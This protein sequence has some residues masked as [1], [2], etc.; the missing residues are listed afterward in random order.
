[1]AEL[2][3]WPEGDAESPFRRRLVAWA[4]ASSK[5]LRRF[6]GDDRFVVRLVPSLQLQGA[7]GLL[8]TARRLHAELEAVGVAVPPR[9]YV[10]GSRHTDGAPQAFV[11]ARTVTGTPLSDLPAGAGAGVA[12]PAEELCVAL[13][14]HLETKFEAGGAYLPD[15]KLEQFVHGWVDDPT[16]VRPYLVDLDPGSVSIE[17]RTAD[18]LALARLQWRIAEVANM[19]V[20]LEGIA[21]VA[22]AAARARLDGVTASPVFAGAEPRVSA[23][24]SAL[25]DGATLDGLEWV[26]EEMARRGARP[27]AAEDRHLAQ[28]LVQVTRFNPE[29]ALSL[30]PRI[31]PDDEDSRSAVV[32]YVER[33]ESG[34][35]CQLQFMTRDGR[36]VH[37][38]LL[39]PDHEET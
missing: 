11:V 16:D 34:E 32:T 35:D 6:E 30:I 8:T 19:V 37:A 13:L 22:F 18:P 1:M 27:P 20:S 24:R 38:H 25:S 17:A 4:S 33:K 10:V 21:G 26:Q 2:W 31:A 29:Q 36:L 14:A 39:P 28:R 7:P 9:L 15:L 23:L 12:G 3:T 5:D